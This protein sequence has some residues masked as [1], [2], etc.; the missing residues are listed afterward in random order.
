MGDIVLSTDEIHFPERGRIV[1]VA[2]SFAGCEIPCC[3][4]SG[5]LVLENRAFFPHIL[6]VQYIPDAVHLRDIAV[7][8]DRSILLSLFKTVS[9][10]GA[11]G[12]MHNDINPGNILFSP[13]NAPTHAVIIDFGHAEY[14]EGDSDEEW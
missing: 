3:Y 10:F 9:A 6:L 2:R 4:G 7:K 8:P 13:R 14:R 1:H 12:V 5:Y 11:L